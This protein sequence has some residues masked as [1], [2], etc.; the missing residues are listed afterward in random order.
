MI[1]FSLI[2]NIVFWNLFVAIIL[3]NFE[4]VNK[5]ESKLLTDKNMETLRLCWA[6]F[7]QEGSG[8]IETGKF[9]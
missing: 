3:N 2:V 5:K 7:D 6:E 9:D 8:F 1:S 4:E